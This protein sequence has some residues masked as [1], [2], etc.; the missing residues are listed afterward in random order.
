MAN[1]SESEC[2]ELRTGQRGKKPRRFNRKTTY[3]LFSNCK[4][5]RTEHDEFKN[6]DLDEEQQPEIAIWPTKPEVQMY[7]SVPRPHRQP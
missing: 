7:V 3:A 2:R 4:P 1:E 5:G 6:S